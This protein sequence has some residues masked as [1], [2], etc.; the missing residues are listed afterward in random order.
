MLQGLFHILES[1]ETPPF[2]AQPFW[3]AE[4]PGHMLSLGLSQYTVNSAAYAY[5]SSG[6]LYGLITDDMV[7]AT[8]LLGEAG[9]NEREGGGG[10]GRDRERR[11]ERE[12]KKRK[13]T[14]DESKKERKENN[15]VRKTNRN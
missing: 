6:E 13:R 3:L 12:K 15:R 9:A 1:Q 8:P 11:K 7:R 10:G 4:E 14:K 5:F 2:E